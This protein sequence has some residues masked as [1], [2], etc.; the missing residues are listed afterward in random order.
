MVNTYSMK[1]VQAGQVVKFYY[2]SE[3][4]LE[5]FEVG[6]RSKRGVFDITE[7]EKEYNKRKSE[8]RS[9]M[10]LADLIN[11]NSYI[12]TNQKGKVYI[13]KFVTFTFAKNMTDR[14]RANKEWDCFIKRLNRYLGY[15]VKYV[16]VPERQKRGAIHYHAVFFNLDYISVNRL[17]DIWRNG[18]I[19]INRVKRVDNVGLYMS[20][21]MGK[22]ISDNEG[23]RR[24]FCSNQLRRA[25]VI[26]D[27]EEVGKIRAKMSEKD[28]VYSKVYDNPYT[29]GVIEFEQ[30]IVK[31]N[32]A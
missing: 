3:A 17:A 32:P 2:Y 8:R 20:K 24:Y 18:F 4:I 22:D 25:E 13:P 5:G 12:Y 21:Y 15:M 23:K 31:K 1:C 30:F 16:V 27:T 28:K 26:K 11:A 10:E 19:K 29:G 9:R 6:E 14:V 7:E